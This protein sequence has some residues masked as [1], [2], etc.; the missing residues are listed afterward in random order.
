MNSSVE[1]SPSDQSPLLKQWYQRRVRGH[2]SDFILDQP[3]YPFSSFFWFGPIHS[4]THKRTKMVR[5]FQLRST[6]PVPLQL[7]IDHLVLDSSFELQFHNAQKDQKIHITDWMEQNNE[8]QRICFFTM[9]EDPDKPESQDNKE[10][11]TKCMEIQKS[12]WKDDSFFI[13]CSIVPEN[14]V[15]NIFKISSTWE[16][17]GDSEENITLVIIDVEVECTRK[18]WGVQGMIEGILEQQTKTSYS[19]WLKLAKEKC[20]TLQNQISSMNSSVEISPSDQSPLLSPEIIDLNSLMVGSGNNVRLRLSTMKKVVSNTDNI[21][22]F[23]AAQPDHILQLQEQ[24]QNQLRLY[25]MQLGQSDE[26]DEKQDRKSSG[27][28]SHTEQNTTLTS[29]IIIDINDQNTFY[30]TSTIPTPPTSSLEQ[31]RIEH[32]HIWNLVFLALL[33]AGTISIGRIVFCLVFRYPISVNTLIGVT[34]ISI[35]VCYTLVLMCK[36]R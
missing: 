31:L 9:T 4:F 17:A 20:S 14:P 30:N 5:V 29:D 32:P 27:N 1:I 28:T 18:I 6:F 33:I 21:A 34:L 23:F 22:Q 36:N 12:C 3:Q 11:A 15:G 19:S 24:I 2:S 25:R 26:K 13:V 7:F 35:T 10:G 8:K 16:I